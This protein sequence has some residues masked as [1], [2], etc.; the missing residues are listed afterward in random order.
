MKPEICI[1]LVRDTCRIL[2][3]PALNLAAKIARERNAYLIPLAC[4]E[5]RRWRN[6]QFGMPRIGVHWARF[7]SESLQSLR[8][9]LIARGSGLWVSAEEPVNALNRAQHSL[10]I[11]GVVCDR[12]I[13][14]EERLET[15]RIKAEGYSVIT[16]DADEL[17]KFE[18]LPFELDELPETFS[19]FR[20]IVEKNSGCLPEHPTEIAQLMPCLDQPWPDPFEWNQALEYVLSSQTEVRTSG[21]ESQA[22]AHWKAY[23]EAK[24]LSH[25]K[26][27]RNAFC[28]PMQSSHLSAWLAHGCI[29]A[30]Q[31]WSDTMEYETTE[32]ANDSTYWLRFELLWREYFRWYSRKS[33]WTLFRRSGPN[34]IEIP[35]DQN[36]TRFESWKT[37]HT[38]CDIVD[39]AM[40]ELNKTGWM[41]NRARQLVASHLIYELHIDWRLG[42]AYFE[43][44][45]VDFDVAS[46]WGNW[47]YIA[48]LGPDPRGGRIFNLNNQANRYDADQS[49]RKRW[50]S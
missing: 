42:A 32:G 20:K 34:A 45:L 13:A 18:Q 40:R 30:R 3:N 24:A 10:S 38:N 35:S 19:K 43:S 5:P 14:T 33:D 37:G 4:L 2:D 41:S 22:Q 17:F 23:Q 47:T 46:N 6:Q 27:T 9:D 11:I 49:Y 44:Q 25:Y 48:G 26:Q 1:W 8:S 31:I 50:L 29:S 7:R 15:A 28:G 21:G 36:I 16:C 12:P 39:A